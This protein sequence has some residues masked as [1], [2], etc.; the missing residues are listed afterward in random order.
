[1]K[2]T[3]I[4]FLALFIGVVSLSLIGCPDIPHTVKYQITGT[5]STVDKVSYVNE[6]EDEDEL[7]NVSIPW[8]KTITVTPDNIYIASCSVY[9][10]PGNT[11]TYTVKIFIDGREV[12]S[13]KG[14]KITTATHVLD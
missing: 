9:P 5:N 11:Y 3:K 7:Y 14:T 13:S 8:E 6:T 10:F 4:V 2:K 12:T 1:M